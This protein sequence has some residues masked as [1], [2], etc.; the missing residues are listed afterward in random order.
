MESR[1]IKNKQ[2]LKNQCSIYWRLPWKVHV[3]RLLNLVQ[4]KLANHK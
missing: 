1:L 2:L 3:V 4:A